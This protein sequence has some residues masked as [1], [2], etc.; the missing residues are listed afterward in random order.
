MFSNAAK[1]HRHHLLAE[2]IFWQDVFDRLEF[3]ILAHN[4]QDILFVDWI[5]H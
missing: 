2:T 3:T 1:H 5:S 4:S